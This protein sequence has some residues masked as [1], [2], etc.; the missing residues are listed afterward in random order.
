MRN[1]DRRSA[2][3]RRWDL[4]IPADAL[5]DPTY[6]ELFHTPHGTDFSFLSGHPRINYSVVDAESFRSTLVDAQGRDDVSV[7]VAPIDTS[8]NVAAHRAVQS[9]VDAIS[10]Q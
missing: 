10:G 8:D 2:Q 4:L 6:S 5:D 7:L 1:D 3:R 9:A